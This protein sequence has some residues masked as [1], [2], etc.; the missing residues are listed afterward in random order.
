MLALVD[1]VR[2]GRA[3]ERQL[4]AKELTSR[5]TDSGW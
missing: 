2:G 3:R 1:A 5:L 4:A